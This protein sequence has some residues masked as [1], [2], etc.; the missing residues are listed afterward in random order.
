MFGTTEWKQTRFYQE[1]AEEAKLQGKLEIVPRLLKK[2]L[3]VQDIAEV[4]E[5]DLKTV[6]KVAKKQSSN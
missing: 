2:G 1:V 5:L 6:Q 4:L 3:T